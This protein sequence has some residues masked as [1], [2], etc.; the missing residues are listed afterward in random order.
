MLIEECLSMLAVEVAVH[1]RRVEVYIHHQ[2]FCGWNQ[3]SEVTGGKVK[4]QLL[5]VAMEEFFLD[6]FDAIEGVVDPK[7]AKMDLSN[8]DAIVADFVYADSNSVG[9]CDWFAVVEVLSLSFSLQVCGC[10]G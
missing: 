4:L 6:G 8:A 3:A 2:R 9:T 1:R 7:V 10:C 5:Y